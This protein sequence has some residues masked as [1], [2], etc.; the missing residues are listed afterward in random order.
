MPQ[1]VAAINAATDDPH[2][3]QR[4]ETV[5]VCVCV[6]MITFTC[7]LVWVSLRCRCVAEDTADR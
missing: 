1:I 4:R 6:N 7:E 3:R 5:S 2:E